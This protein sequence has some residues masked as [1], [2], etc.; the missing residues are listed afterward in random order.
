MKIVLI[1][2]LILMCTSNI[3]AQ[4]LP[5]G[6]DAKKKIELEEKNLRGSSYA[7]LQLKYAPAFADYGAELGIKAGYMF[8]NNFGL[9]VATFYL[10]SKPLVDIGNN[11]RI[12]MR[13]TYYGIVP[14]FFYPLSDRLHLSAGVFAGLSYVDYG[15]GTGLDVP[16]TLNG[17]WIILIEPGIALNIKISGSL[18]VG[19]TTAYRTAQGVQ[20]FNITQDEMSGL[21]SGIQL[22]FII[23]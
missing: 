3:L 23:R 14:E 5:G 9:A 11:K 17:D 4:F 2:T 16:A 13:M 7:E 6:I 15:T 20:L 19:F 12:V 21:F 18:W 1:T 10:L 22:R 8:T